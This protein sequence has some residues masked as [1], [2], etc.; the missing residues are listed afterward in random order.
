MIENNDLKQIEI[1][2]NIDIL[3]FVFGSGQL[4]SSR[5]PSMARAMG[6]IIR[7]SV[8]L[9]SFENIICQFEIFKKGEYQN[10]KYTIALYFIFNCLK[11]LVY[12]GSS[13][14]VKERLTGHEKVKPSDLYVLVIPMDH[15]QVF[16]NWKARLKLIEKG[17][18]CILNPIRNEIGYIQG[19]KRR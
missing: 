1:R 2:C 17:L 16:K 15:L 9:N 12:I 14:K 7:D 10:C 8:K 13:E 4:I 6:K 18:I 19:R 11:D 3:E 5:S